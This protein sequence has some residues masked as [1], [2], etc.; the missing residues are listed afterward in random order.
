M[1]GGDGGGWLRI[2]HG[3]EGLRDREKKREERAGLE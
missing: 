1:R 3:D 2:I